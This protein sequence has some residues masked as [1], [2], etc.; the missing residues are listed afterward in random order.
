MPAAALAATTLKLSSDIVQLLRC[1]ACRSSLNVG[2]ERCKCLSAQCGREYPVVSEIPI[3]IV[4]ERSVFS[5]SDFTAQRADTFF[6]DRK[7]GR[8]SAILGKLLP[9]STRNV[10]AKQCYE[11][12]A[13]QLKSAAPEPRVLVIGGSILGYGMAPLAEDRSIQ[14]VD[15]DVS[16]GLRTKL[17]CDAHDLPF[18]DGS[19]DGVVAQAVLEHVVDPQRC[20]AEFHRVLKP[21][22]LV[23]AETPFMQQ[24]HA[25][26]PDFTRFSHLGH[27]RLFRMFDEISSGV[28]CGPGMA[29]SWSFQYFL[30]S[31]GRSSGSVQALRGLGRLA[32]FWLKYFDGYL[33]K[34][35]GGYDSASAVFFLGRKSNEAISDKALLKLYRG[36]L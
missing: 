33:S 17:I 35:R 1:P 29:L 8:A 2:S 25:G 9:S 36:A 24:V 28:A 22:G 5:V 18:E 23:Y 3:L 21:D 32:S 31:F 34:Q 20:V 26:P 7:S 6:K 12:L 13:A 30:A 4:D 14:L 11:D 10:A 16:F 27:R 15:T 19:F